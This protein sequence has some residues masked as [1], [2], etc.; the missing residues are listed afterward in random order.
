MREQQSSL[1][2]SYS[3]VTVGKLRKAVGGAASSGI[4]CRGRK[5]WVGEPSAGFLPLQPWAQHPSHRRRLPLPASSP[6]LG[7]TADHSVAEHQRQSTAAFF[8]V[9]AIHC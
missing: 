4:L 6:F 8:P 7:V 1:S 5:G 2:A 3:L 9:A